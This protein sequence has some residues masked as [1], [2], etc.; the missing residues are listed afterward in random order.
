MDFFE[1][2]LIFLHALDTIITYQI[3]VWAKSLK[4]VLLECF[5]SYGQNCWKI[6]KILPIFSCEGYFNHNL[7]KAYDGQPETTVQNKSHDL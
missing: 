1:V 3:V 2:R 4:K 7:I 5:W 6:D